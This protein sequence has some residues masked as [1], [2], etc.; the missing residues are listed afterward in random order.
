[1]QLINPQTYLNDLNLSKN[2]IVFN[3]CL[4][5]LCFLQYILLGMYFQFQLIN[6]QTYLNGLNTSKEN[7]IVFNLYLPTGCPV[8]EGE[9][10]VLRENPQFWPN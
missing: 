4:P 2:R 5:N 10:L 1:M 6:P 8:T 7:T 3:L 9:I